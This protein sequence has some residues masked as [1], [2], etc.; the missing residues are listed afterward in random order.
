MLLAEGLLHD[1][2][3][4]HDAALDLLFL[5]GLP[6]LSDESLVILKV[7]TVKCLETWNPN[8]ESCSELGVLELVREHRVA[9]V[10]H[11]VEVLE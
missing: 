11:Q 4:H 2:I 3:A 5:L 6:H 10:L 1:S 9:W 8:G 7:S